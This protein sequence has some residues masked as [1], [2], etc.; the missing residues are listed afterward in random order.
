LRRD[1]LEPSGE[2]RP[3]LVIRRASP[4]DA[5]GI[6]ECLAAAFEPFRRSYTPAGF[7]DTVLA[8]EMLARRLSEMSVF[9]AAAAGRVVG[10]VGCA[11][12]ASGEGHIRGMAVRPGWQG[13]GVA[14]RLLFAAEKELRQ[15]GCLRVTLDTTAPLARAIRF[16]ESNGYCATGRIGDF[17]GM[18]LFEYAR[19]LKKSRARSRE[20]GVGKPLA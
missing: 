10:T 6:L 1:S 7:A 2:V 17:F 20:S 5:A 8:P 4:E 3:A 15:K 13:R 11:P 19:A 12:V 14:R 16:Y 9:V 18:P